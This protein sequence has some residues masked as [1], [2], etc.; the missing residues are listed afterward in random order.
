MLVANTLAA[1]VLLKFRELPACPE[2]HAL[3]QIFPA[4]QMQLPSHEDGKVVFA[5]AKTDRSD[6]VPEF[7]DLFRG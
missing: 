1:A 4:A 5:P 6:S 3:G 7:L 2:L